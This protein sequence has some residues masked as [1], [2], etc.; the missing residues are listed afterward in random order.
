M[1]IFAYI[2]SYRNKNSYTNFFV[3]RLINELSL[4]YSVKENDIYICMPNELKINDCIGC[5]KCFFEGKCSILDDMSIVKNKLIESDLIIFAS[6]VYV[7]QI[8]GCFKT[9]I[10]RIGYWTHTMKLTGKIG[11]SVALSDSNGNEFV[12]E[13]ISKVMQYLGIS[14]IS[15][16][17]VKVQGISQSALESI[18]RYESN[19]IKKAIDKKNFPITPLQELYYQKQRSSVLSDDNDIGD[20]EKKLLRSENIKE[21]RYFIEYFASKMKDSN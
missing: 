6:P 8:T 19:K 11:V 7:H 4:V 1:K 3:R 18:I 14:V 10:D 21:Y 9:F 20:F 16:I 15:Q 17:E 13:Y 12:T 5:S 2:G